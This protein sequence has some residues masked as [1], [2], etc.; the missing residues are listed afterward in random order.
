[1]NSMTHKHDTDPASVSRHTPESTLKVEAR[2]LT[3]DDGDLSISWEDTEVEATLQ[4]GF[5]R[6]NI[7]M[8]RCAGAGYV[9]IGLDSDGMY[10]CTEVATEITQRGGGDV[11]DLLERAAEQLQT[12]ARGI[13]QTRGE[14]PTHVELG[15]GGHKL[16]ATEA[17]H[18]GATLIAAAEDM[19]AK[20]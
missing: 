19:E 14:S 3:V 1:M 10:G 5:K 20:A 13:R 15:P 11:V 6:T 4:A 16:T 9:V 2:R 18:I 12:L 17:R 8:P 7:Y